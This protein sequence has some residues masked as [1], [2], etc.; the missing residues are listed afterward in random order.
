MAE[1][2]I[3]KA[4]DDGDFSE[5]ERLRRLLATPFAEH[6]D[7]AHYAGAAPDWAQGLAVSCSS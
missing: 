2:A 7:M 4:S 6:P 5:I 3:R 1:I